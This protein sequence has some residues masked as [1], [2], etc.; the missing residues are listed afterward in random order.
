MTTE[1]K[2]AI[3]AALAQEQADG[4]PRYVVVCFDGAIETQEAMPYMGVEWYTT[5]GIQHG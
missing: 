4:R 3:A 5:D 1:L 2:T